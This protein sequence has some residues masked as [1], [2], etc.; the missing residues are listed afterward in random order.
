MGEK[1]AKPG[2]TEDLILQ[3]LGSRRKQCTGERGL[4]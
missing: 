2:G 1:K 3:A 4:G